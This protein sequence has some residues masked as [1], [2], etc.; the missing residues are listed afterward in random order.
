MEDLGGDEEG[1]G[2]EQE[3]GGELHGNPG[4]AA[5]DIEER[6]GEGGFASGVEG[7]EKLDYPSLRGRIS[8]G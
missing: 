5:G 3:G 6:D 2:E 7:G 8:K 4:E 1:G